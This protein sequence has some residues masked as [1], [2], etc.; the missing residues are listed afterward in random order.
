MLRKY[1]GYTVRTICTYFDYIMLLEPYIAYVL[2][3]YCV[4]KD[5]CKYCSYMYAVMALCSLR[6]AAICTLLVLYV[7]A[8]CTQLWL[9]VIFFLRLYVCAVAVCTLLGQYVGLHFADR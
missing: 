2:R 7:A 4:V 1:V 9:Y 6:V 8:I 5:I 3:L